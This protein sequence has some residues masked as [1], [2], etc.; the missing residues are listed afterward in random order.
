MQVGN[1]R[2]TSFWGDVWCDQS[3]LKDRFPEIYDI[4]IEQSVT[5]ADAAAMNWSFFSFRRWMTPDIALQIH[6]LTH[7]MAQTTLNNDPDKPF[8]K[9]T[10]V[11]NFSMKSVYDHLCGSGMDR[12]FKNLS[13]NKIPLKI[14]IWLWMIWHNAIATKDNLLK[15]NWQG[16]ATCQF[17]EDTETISHLFFPVQLLSMSGVLLVR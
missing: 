11:G 14:K 6:G 10:K 12:T 15:R 4:C 16:S 17:C 1:G 13:K 8:W 7:I 3:P 9:W 2:N 5:V